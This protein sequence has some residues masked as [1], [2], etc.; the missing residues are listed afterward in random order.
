MSCIKIN[1]N[2]NEWAPLNLWEEED[3]N[4]ASQLGCK[5]SQNIFDVL[6]YAFTMKNN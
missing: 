1:F 2:K 5:V 4:L 6:R 3:L